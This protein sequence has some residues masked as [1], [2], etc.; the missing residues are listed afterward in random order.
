MMDFAVSSMMDAP[1]SSV[2]QRVYLRLKPDDGPTFLASPTV[3]PVATSMVGPLPS[4]VW[5][6]SH[7]RRQSDDVFR[8]QFDNGRTI[9]SNPTMGLSSP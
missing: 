4:S 3:N 5:R 9:V 1:S 7:L 8:R 6:C 2:R